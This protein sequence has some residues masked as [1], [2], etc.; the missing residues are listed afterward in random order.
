MTFVLIVDDDPAIRTLLADMFS[1]EGYRVGTAC[2]GVEALER[3]RGRP[4]D[5]IV[6]DLMM[7]TLGGMGFLDVCRRES[8]CREV[9]VMVVSAEY[10]LVDE[11]P[12]LKT[13]GVRAVLGKPFD[14]AE[15]L[16]FVEQHAPRAAHGRND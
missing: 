12:A 4:P 13:A 1:E 2:N 5:A 7:P 16:E 15:V 11:M 3:V 10:A 9:P 6:L 14:V 8:L